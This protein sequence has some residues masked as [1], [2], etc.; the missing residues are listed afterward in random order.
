MLTVLAI[1]VQ[2]YH[3]GLEDDSFYL[4]AIRKDLNP[5]LYPHDSDFFQ[6]QFQATAYDELIAWSVRITHLPLDWVVLFYQFAAILLIL[7]ACG[8][9]ARKCFRERHAEWAA[10]ALV[11]VLLT[12]PISG[13]GLLLVDQYLHP[14][15][16]ATAAILWAVAYALE[17]SAAAAA[18]LL[19]IAASLHILMAAFGVSC[20]LFLAD[21][22]KIEALQPMV[23]RAAAAAIF[24][25]LG[26]VFDAPNH[27][28]QQ[29]AATRT[30]Y[31]LSRWAW[32]EWLGVAA[33]L[34]IFWAYSYIARRSGSW[35]AARLS[36]RIMRFGV[37]QMVIALAIMLP[38]GME[39]LRPLE[40]MRYL[41]LIY[42]F[43]FLLG[44][45]FIGKHV[46]AGK[47]WRWAA[48]FGPLSIGM[49]FAQRQ[50]YPASQHLE[51]PGVAQRN[52]W[53][54]AF[55][56]IREN[57]PPDSLFALDPEYMNLPG[58]D[59]HGFRAIA[60]RS[61]LV[62]NL[63]DP[64]MVARVPR[65]AERW[66]AESLAQ[67]NWRNFQLADFRRLKG[68]FGV[69]W[70]VLAKPCVEGLACPWENRAVRVCRVE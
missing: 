37:F 64:G 11:A 36:L 43:L 19:G 66:Q 41:H 30:F 57:T 33:P 13:T 55:V 69:D 2:G 59:S 22:R 29:A 42:L 70:V 49:L 15:A 12:I 63:K 60:A 58:E 61:A 31:F 46:L 9:I 27:A 10:M 18:V 28:W 53:V 45:G 1:A 7:W 34:L 21:W 32:Y 50:L 44:G 39:R 62:D 56:W 20:C 38:R 25:P 35:A 48:L 54:Q 26:W 24:L 68:Q 17:G 65:L 14:R 23:K 6:L 8:R 51:L 16:L 40:P 5:A 67:S 47:A 52:E 3:P 4:A